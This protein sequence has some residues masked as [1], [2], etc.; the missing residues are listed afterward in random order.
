MEKLKNS[1]NA[2]SA[3]TKNNALALNK[4]RIPKKEAGLVRYGTFIH[5]EH[6]KQTAEELRQRIGTYTRTSWDKVLQSGFNCIS[7]TD[8]SGTCFEGEIS[9]TTRIN[10]RILI[11]CRWV[12]ALEPCFDEDGDLDT[13]Q[14]KWKPW[15]ETN[16]FFSLH[17][18]PRL[19][20]D[21]SNVIIQSWLENCASQT[22]FTTTT[23]KHVSR[24]ESL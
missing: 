3:V 4:H 19:V 23:L 18:I 11:T 10:D 5:L 1:I 13:D 16:T 21:S 2:A 15:S 14:M 6:V 22:Y 24:F 8:Y 9:S 12:N 17:D 7:N 20:P